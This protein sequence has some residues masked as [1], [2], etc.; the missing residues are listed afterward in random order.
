MAL[1]ITGKQ[2]DQGPRRVID[3]GKQPHDHDDLHDHGIWAIKS[4]LSTFHAPSQSVCQGGGGV[5]ACLCTF[6]A[7]SLCAV[8]A[9]E[10]AQIELS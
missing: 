10:Q 5:H 4:L 6:L 7:D 1:P 9:V 2:T 3:L 8:V